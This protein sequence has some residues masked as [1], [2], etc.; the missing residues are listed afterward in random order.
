MRGAPAAK[1]ASPR[2]ARSSP[3][4]APQSFCGHGIGQLF[5]TNPNI[6]HYRNNEPN[7]VM[8]AGHTLTIEPMINEGTDRSVI[9]PDKWTVTSSDGRRSAQV[10]SP[11][12]ARPP[13]DIMRDTGR[14]LSQFEHTLLI[15]PTGVEPLTGKLP[16]SPVQPWERA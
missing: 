16:T 3:A 5:H 15:T 4:R 6:L 11:S 9:W 1:R 7:G 8:A 14:A 12:S 13:R 10:R 2:R